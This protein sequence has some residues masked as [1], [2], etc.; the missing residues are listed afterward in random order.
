[1]NKIYRGQ[2]LVAED[3]TS[4]VPEDSPQQHTWYNLDMQINWGK[5]YYHPSP[6]LR[7]IQI[8][9]LILI[10]IGLGL[11]IT[12]NIW[13][14]K[15]VETI[16]G[17]ETFS[18]VPLPTASST[19]VIPPVIPPVVRPGKVDTGVEGIVTIGPTCPVMRI[20]PDP[21]CADKTYQTTLVIASN[22]PGKGGGILVHTDSQGY[23]SQELVPGT[24]TISAQANNVM[25]RL[26]PVTFVVT[27]HKLTSLNLQFDS[28]IR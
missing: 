5:R 21:Q 1:M 17:S 8:V 15:L 23:F 4:R 12:Q 19:T 3:E 7:T 26:S 6:L 10:I 9:L 13:V 25:P 22:L 28:G 24:Y 16:V 11:L 2:V 27:N 20:P 18:V 14:P